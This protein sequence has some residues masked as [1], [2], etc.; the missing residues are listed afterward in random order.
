VL[1]HA[2]AQPHDAAAHSNWAN[3][4]LAAGRR[5]KRC[6]ISRAWTLRP[7]L[8]QA[9]ANEASH[10]CS[11]RFPHRVGQTT[12]SFPESVRRRAHRF[13]G[14]AGTA[15]NRS[16]E[17]P[18][19]CHAEQGLGDTIQFALPP[20]RPAQ[21]ATG[22]LLRPEPLRELL[23]TLPRCE[24][25]SSRSGRSAAGLRLSLFRAQP[26]SRAWHRAH[27]HSKATPI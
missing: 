27:Q 7:E 23:H 11:R 22:C 24:H 14:H 5:R 8:H 20:A 9:R 4:L 16:L 26:A 12:V 25:F 18:F 13:T 10:N 3:L 17:K 6:G 15:P 2:S 21:G 19:S 1:R